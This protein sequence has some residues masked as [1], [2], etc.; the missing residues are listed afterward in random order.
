MVEG[1]TE[2]RNYGITEIVA[3]ASLPPDNGWKPLPHRGNDGITE[4]GCATLTQ[5]VGCNTLMTGFEKCDSFE[6]SSG[7]NY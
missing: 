2:R 6:V 4:K 3:A 5:T 7:G 1:M